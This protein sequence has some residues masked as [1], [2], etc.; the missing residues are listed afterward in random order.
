MNKDSDTSETIRAQNETQ[1]I[2]EEDKNVFESGIVF[3][4][5]INQQSLSKLKSNVINSREKQTQ[6]NS[7]AS[8]T[9]NQDI[10]HLEEKLNN[11]ANTLSDVVK[12]KGQ[13]EERDREF[14]DIKTAYPQ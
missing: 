13:F 4:A 14:N 10:K 3:D 1:F 2:V 12:I 8:I 6:T 11:I 5:S 9:N 7:A